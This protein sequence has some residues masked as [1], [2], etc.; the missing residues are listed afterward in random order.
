M[1]YDVGIDIGGTFTDLCAIAEDGTLITAKSPTTHYDLSVGLIRGLR[2]LGKRAG[3]AQD[4][5]LGQVEALRYSTTIGTNALIERKGPRLGLITT[6]GFEDTIFI[7]RSRSWADGMAFHEIR[8]MAVI[9]KPEPLVA[10]DMVMGLS[11]RLDCN[12]RV[13]RALDPDELREKLQTLVDRGVQGIVVSLLWSFMNPAHEREIRRIIEEE[14]P[15]EFLG[16]M[17]VTLASE[18]SPKAGEYTRT[19]TALVNAYIHGVMMQELGDLTHNLR[20]ANYRRPLILVHNTGGSKKV[21]RTRA[22]LTHNA[23]PVAGMYGA[24]LIGAQEGVKDIVFADMGGTSFDIGVLAGGVLRAQDFIPVIDRWRTNIPAIEVRSI[25]AGGGSIAWINQA[26]GGQLEVGPQSAGSVPG[27]ACYDQGGQEPTVTDADLVLGY[28]NPDNYLGGAMLLD[29]DAAHEAIRS[30][31]AEP[32]GI[33]VLEA[34][35]RIRRLIDARMGQEMFNEV[36]LKGHNPRRFA[37]Y[38]C[39]GAG[40]GHACGFARH[41]GATTIIVPAMSSVSGAFGASSMEIRQVWEQSRSLRLFDFRTQTYLADPEA[42]NAVIADLTDRATRDLKLE[43]F[44]ADRIAFTL[45]FDMRYGSQYHLTRVTSPTLSFAGADDFRALCDRFEAQY[46]TVYSPEAAFPSGGIAIEAIFVTAAIRQEPRRLNGSDET[47]H[48]PE[49]GAI[50][51][52][53]FDAAEGMVDTPVHD[54]TALRPGAEIPGPAIIEAP[55]TTYVIEPG[56][57]YRMNRL[58]NGIITAQG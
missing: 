2:E 36:A 17:P 47:P 41:V 50:R 29:P 56:W 11:E 8:D 18:V 40:A 31:I 43:G 58:R 6:A 55:D 32:L 30:R 26:M 53:C 15:E 19:M 25:G 27:P 1:T 37:V 12:G 35:W 51:P 33:S 24:A 9:R 10:P 16:S 14:Y 49:P 28:V 13:I 52:A 3:L 54:W 45:E 57:I 39:G 46:A 7:G 34:A 22:V 48:H 38:A 4:S 23:G 42:L 44:D 5:F 21:S 20:R